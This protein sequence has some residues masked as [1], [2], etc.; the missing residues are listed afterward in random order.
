MRDRKELKRMAKD[1]LRTSYW[2]ASVVSL[3]LVF[4]GEGSGIP[5]LNQRMGSSSHRVDL[6]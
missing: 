1:V 4:L 5:S 2:K 6:S 3:I